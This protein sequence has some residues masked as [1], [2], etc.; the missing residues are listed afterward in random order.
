M[1]ALAPP[2]RVMVPLAVAV[3]AYPRLPSGSVRDLGYLAIGLLAVAA[4]VHGLSRKGAPHRN[5]WLVVTCAYLGWLADHTLRTLGVDADPGPAVV[6]HLA[7]YAVL[8][9]GLLLLVRGRGERRDRTAALD[10]TF[11]AA[12]L[13][14]VAV[15]FLITPI[16]RDPSLTLAGRLAGSAQPLADVL[17]LSL[18]VRLWITP[19][20]KPA[21]YRL[22]AAAVALTV[23]GDVLSDYRSVVDPAFGSPVVQQ[24]LWLAGYVLV[25][26]AAT[27][28]AAP[29]AER[30]F[31]QTE[32]ADARRRLLVL[33]AGLT[34]PV[35]ALLVDGLTSESLEWPVV[36]GGSLLI[37]LL[38][39]VQWGGLL[40]QGQDQAVALAALARADALTGIPNRRTWDFELERSAK[41][42]QELNA[43]LTVA[44]LDLDHLQKYNQTHGHATGDRLLREAAAAWSGLLQPGQVLAR[45]GGD[46]FA[47]LCPG[48]WAADVRPVLDAMR[49]ATPAGQTVS[50]GVATWDPHTEPG[51][52][53]TTA[54]QFVTE[55]KRGGRDQVQVAPRPTSR[56][57][58]PRPS[59]FWQP[60]VE[61]RTTRPVGV[62]ALSRFPGSD[63]LTVFQQ[64]ASVGSGPALEAVAITYALT[65]RP[66]GLWVAVNV[67]LEALGSVSV[68]RALAGDLTDVVLEI[69]EHSDTAVPD[70]AELLRDYRARGASIAVDD[71]GPGFSNL[72]RLLTLQ[73]DI[74]K[75]DVSRVASLDSD[76]AR[77]SIRL[78]AAWAESAGAR[79]CAEGVETEEQWRQLCD[80]GIHLGQGHFFGRPM[81][82]EELLSLPRD[83][84]APR[85]APV[86]AP[87]GLR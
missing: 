36:A 48:L 73:P 24:L 23:A 47:L 53:L 19:G 68:Q 40:N 5:S 76:R 29:E 57:L 56:T 37:W 80:V 77:A 78:I 66:E 59:I 26:G 49:A 11:L 44:L 31:G 1:I 58:L 4:A 32:L 34:L 9:V 18:L 81:P 13:A 12:G 62:E 30:A 87:R 43:P 45:Y 75:V 14:V 2:V 20:A 70:L 7:S 86:L 67:S 52:A 33:A 72:D 39:V 69:T 64:A 21:A 61:L 22:L 42:A 74:V 83:T 35:A 3:A 50:I 8:A 63:P 46:E 82:P 85:L 84:V 27:A 60:I 16:A 28:S 41:A 6:V 65:N 10:A 71:W 54:S 17:L 25:A 55:A 51:A 79:V 15:V 38:I